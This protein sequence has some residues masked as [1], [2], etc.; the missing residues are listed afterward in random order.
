MKVVLGK[1]NER[2]DIMKGELKFRERMVENGDELN[3]MILFV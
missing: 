1:L 3:F 2:G